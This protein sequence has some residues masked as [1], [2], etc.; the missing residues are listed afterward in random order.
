MTC[1]NALVRTLP[2]GLV[3][4][5][6]VSSEA[7]ADKLWKPEYRETTA[8]ETSVLV[9]VGVIFFIGEYTIPEPQTPRIRHGVLFDDA[10]RSHLRAPGEAG[11]RRA[12]ILSDYGFWGLTAAP[13][14]DAGLTAGAVHGDGQTAWQLARIDAEAFALNETLTLVTKLLTARQRPYAYDAGCPVDGC[15]ANTSFPSG[16]TSRAFTGAALICTT[17]WYIPMFGGPWDA[18]ACAGALGVATTTGI[19][20]IVADKHW[21][22]DVIAG[23]LTGSLS[24]WLIPFLHLHDGARTSGTASRTHLWP[25]VAS[26][27]DGVSLGIGGSLR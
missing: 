10:V 11:R 19:M 5:L 12:D 25:L 8:L 23:A 26:T 4:A 17:H 18:V 13:F 9:G 20:R 14:L 2:L 7:R 21:S 16:H 24:G 3:G 22:T 1:T 27:G 15:I 6:V